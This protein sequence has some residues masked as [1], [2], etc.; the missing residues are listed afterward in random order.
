[1]RVHIGWQHGWRL[2]RPA[3]MPLHVGSGDQHGNQSDDPLRPNR[4]LPE[5]ASGDRCGPNIPSLRT[6][7]FSTG[8]H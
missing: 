4:T 1:M 8:G 6:R 3:L 5:D 2:M 7:T